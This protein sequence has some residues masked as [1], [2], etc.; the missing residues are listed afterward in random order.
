MIE[1]P[2]Q[3][4]DFLKKFGGK[5][6]FNEPTFILV[7]CESSVNRIGVPPQ[8][9]GPYIKSWILCE[10]CPAEEFGSPLDWDDKLM[11]QPFPSRGLYF[12]LQIFKD[13]DGH[14]P[15]AL[16]SEALN[17]EVLGRWLWNCINHKRD[18]LA[19][20]LAVFNEEDEKKQKAELSR[21]ADRLQDA[22]PAFGMADAVSFQGQQGAMCSLRSR[23]QE[24]EKKLPAIR[25]FRRRIPRGISVLNP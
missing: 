15:A 11:Q 4:S 10:W 17:P 1:T 12:P 13:R 2:K 14:T 16:D 20:R 23:M 21:L 5:N 6:P 18:S 19:K 22:F 25:D 7:W 24:I 3:Y 8:M 9:F